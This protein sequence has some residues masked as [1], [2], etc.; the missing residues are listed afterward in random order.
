MNDVYTIK[1]HA[2]DF[3][4][5]LCYKLY[6]RRMHL[7]Y[8]YS[9]TTIILVYVQYRLHHQPYFLSIVTHKLINQDVSTD[10]SSTQLHLT[11]PTYKQPSTIY[12]IA[13][14]FGFHRA[15]TYRPSEEIFMVLNF[16][17][18]LW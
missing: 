8:Y 13:E 5:K 3:S 11:T 10:A 12:H 16:M 7:A 17:P 1:V 2:Y 6:I 9:T 14:N 15:A 18:V 4:L